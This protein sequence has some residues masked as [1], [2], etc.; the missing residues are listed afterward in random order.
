[1]IDIQLSQHFM[2]S[3]FLKSNIASERGLNNCPNLAVISNLQQI[4]LHVLE[5]I[6]EQFGPHLHVLAGYQCLEILYELGLAPTS[7]HLLGQ[8]VDFVVKLPSTKDSLEGLLTVFGWMCDNI[9]YDELYMEYLLLP[10]N[11]KKPRRRIRIRTNEQ[12]PYHYFWIHV[13]YVSP[14][15]NRHLRRSPETL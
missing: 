10:E 5:P 12:G 1:M 9:S 2:L 8:A 13:S 15:K 6:V 7:Q 3:N 4:C 14:D 11:P